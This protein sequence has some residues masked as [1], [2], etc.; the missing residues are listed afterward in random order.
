MTEIMMAKPLD[1]AAGLEQVT[2][3]RYTYLLKYKT[4]RK[5]HDTIINSM[6]PHKDKY[7]ILCNI[8]EGYQIM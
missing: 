3:D 2:T 8:S 1:L 4:C 7:K 6:S 5:D